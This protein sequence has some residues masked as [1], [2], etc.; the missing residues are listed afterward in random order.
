MTEI[1]KHILA[2]DDD[3]FFR[4]QLRQLLET[5]GYE[6]DS[7]ETGEAAIA[8]FGEN[9]FA[10]DRFNLI[11]LD[12]LMPQP[13]GFKVFKHLKELSVASRTPILILSVLGLKPKVQDLLEEGAHHLKKDEVTTQLVAKVKELIG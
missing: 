13:D 2:I 9:G 12:L 11:I 7:V 6:V 8:C 5:A 10:K 3:Y 4:M 1:R